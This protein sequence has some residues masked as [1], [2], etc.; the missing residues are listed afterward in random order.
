[1]TKAWKI[2]PGE[3]AEDWEVSRKQG[4]ICLGWMQIPD[5]ARFK[6]E[7][8]IL[9]ALKKSYPH[10]KEGNRG[11]AAKSIWRFGHK[12]QPHQLVIANKGRSSVVGIGVVTSGYIPP[13]SPENPV[14]NDQRIWRRHARLVDWRIKQPIDFDHYLFSPPTV[15][16]LSPEV[17]RKIRQAY[18]KKYPN[19]KETLDRLFD[20][21]WA[22]DDGED[23]ATSRFRAQEGDAAEQIALEILDKKQAKGQGFRLHTKLRLALE[24]Y[25]MDAAKARFASLGF[26]VE[27][28][29]KNR[30]YDLYCRRGKQVLYVEVKGTQANGEQIILTNGEVKFA[31]SHEAEMALFIVHS[32][33]VTETKGGFHLAEGDPR[34]IRPWDIDHRWLS[35]LAFMYRIEGK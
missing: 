1:M 4:C 35:P 34:L 15:H 23:S 24:K 25:A 17:L 10:D 31:R 6:R 16:S 26:V 14:R 11:G 3:G 27:D 22:T 2:A 30:P 28:H 32:I 8:E 21:A 7:E 5:F 12:I 13:R 18:A 29:S 9:R 33:K 19:M 20:S